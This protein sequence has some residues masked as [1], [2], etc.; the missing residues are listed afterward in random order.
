MAHKLSARDFGTVITLSNDEGSGQPVHMS[1]LASVFTA[2]KSHVLAI[3]I[4]DLG[5]TKLR[6]RAAK[7][8]DSLQFK[9][10]T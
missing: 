8:A 10:L 5:D 4:A 6:I 1:R 9:R 3:K 2:H 7:T